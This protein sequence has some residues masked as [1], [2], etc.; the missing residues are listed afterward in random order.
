MN[1]PDDFK[2]VENIT[3]MN[4]EPEDWWILSE[5]NRTISVM[6]S[7]MDEY[8][9]HITTDA[10]YTFVWNHFCDWY[11]E[12]IKP[13]IFGKMGEESLATAQQTV[14]Y[15]LNTMIHLLHPFMPFLTEELYSFVCNWKKPR[16]K[17]EELCT[18]S[19]WPEN[20]PLSE[21]AIASGLLL[22]YLQEIITS[23]RKVRAESGIGPDKKVSLI[24]KTEQE[25]LKSYIISRES[26]ILRLVQL[27]SLEISDTYI[28]GK[29]DSIESFSGGELYLPLE[30]LMDLEK[31]KARLKKELEATRSQISGLTK[32]LAQEGFIKNAPPEVLVKE[33]SRLE[34]LEEKER[35]LSLSLERWNS[36]KK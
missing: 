9:F 1:L 33:K 16:N 4:L 25:N 29:N 31:E 26:S 36:D 19:S 30:G 28:P 13:R 10:I 7:S 21:N 2:P 6:E 18:T 34:E 11:I 22:Q 35:V 23:V 24:I 14:F 32:K 8:K 20:V 3:E 12:L 17:L 15:A 5:L 27:S